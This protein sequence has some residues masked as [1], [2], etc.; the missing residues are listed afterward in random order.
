VRCRPASGILAIARAL[1]FGARALVIDEPTAPLTV[2]QHALV[3]QSVVVARGQGL[4]V[5]F[6]T[7]NPRFAELVGNRFLLLAHGSVAGNFARGEVDAADLTRL[8]AGGEELASL[9]GSLIELI[10]ELRER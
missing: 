7:N 4:A 6:V 5:L 1:H 10:P 8:M 9:S 3:L 2:A